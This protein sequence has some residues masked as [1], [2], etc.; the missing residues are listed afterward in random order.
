MNILPLSRLVRLATNISVRHVGAAHRMPTANSA[1][2]SD[3]GDRWHPTGQPRCAATEQAVGSIYRDERALRDNA[4]PLTEPPYDRQQWY[5]VTGEYGLIKFNLA[6]HR[7]YFDRVMDECHRSPS[8]VYA[9]LIDDVR[10]DTTRLAQFF[11]TAGRDRY[12]SETAAEPGLCFR[13]EQGG[14]AQCLAPYP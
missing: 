6:D 12:R 13:P 1:G 7:K 9:R 11:E 10:N 14:A 5:S 4:Y 8:A 2:Q 3:A